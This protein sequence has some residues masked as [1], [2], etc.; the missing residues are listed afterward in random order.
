MRALTCIVTGLAAAAIS[1]AALAQSADRFDG[2]WTTVVTC[3]AAQGA[4]GFTILVDADIKNGIFR[5]EK[6]EQGKPGWYSLTGKVAAD[7][8]VNLFARGIVPSSRLAAGNVPV[9][10]PY[11]YPVTG[12]LEGAKGTGARQGGRPCSV[13]F[14]KQ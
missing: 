5:G 7:G 8:S 3:S 11:G 14:T 2:K 6:G 12:R 10:T 13:A 1:G 4:G 9:G